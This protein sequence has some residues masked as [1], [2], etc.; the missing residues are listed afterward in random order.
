M[1]EINQSSACVKSD[2]FGHF[3]RKRLFPV[4]KYDLLLNTLGVAT[5]ADYITG[6]S[7]TPYFKFKSRYSGREFYI[8]AKYLL[9][10]SDTSVEWCQPYELKKYQ[11]MDSTT[12]VY[13]LIG[14]GPQPAAPRHVFMFP[15]K[16]I[17]FNR[18]LHSYI[19]K[20]QISVN[21][22]IEDKDL[23]L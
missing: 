15:V 11:K 4:N 2:D 13:I 5:S 10:S 16:S 3:I 9:E 12:P 14:S 1:S 7:R 22:S 17:R 8:D 6:G 23:A 21:R 19:E 18:V 20:Y